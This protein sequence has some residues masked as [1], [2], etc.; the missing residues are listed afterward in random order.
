MFLTIKWQRVAF[1]LMLILL[2]ELGLAV[3]LMFDM[4][5]ANP[6]AKQQYTVV[7]DAGHGGIDGGVVAADG[8]KE[9]DLNLA[10][11]LTLGDMLTNCGFSVVYTRKIKGG[12]Y[13]AA[14][15]GFKGRD[16][17]ARK[18]IV[19]DTAPVLVVSIHMNKYTG[20][21]SRRGPQVFYQ[22]GYE[23]GK[24]FAECMQRVLNDFTGNAHSALGGDYYMC[25]E[26]PCPSVICEC[27]FLS[28]PDEAHLLTDETYRDELCKEIL[29]GIVY[30]LAD[31]A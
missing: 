2:A 7:V 3:W 29:R 10:Y 16:M 17:R 26:M 23:D 1:V 22:K 15:D 8:T 28:N 11:A 4:Q 24:A 25:R 31:R 21:T 18:Q 5:P 14:T 12:L 9:S 20:S 13:G 6:A 19:V 27:G 30:Y